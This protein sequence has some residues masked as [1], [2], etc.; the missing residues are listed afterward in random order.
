MTSDALCDL[1]L[2]VGRVENPG[3]SLDPRVSFLAET[4]STT[5]S[6]LRLEFLR[7]SIMLLNMDK[8]ESSDTE[9]LLFLLSLMELYPDSP[10]KE[11]SSGFLGIDIVAS[12]GLGVNSALPDLEASLV[13]G[14][15]PKIDLR[16]EVDS[17]KEQGTVLGGLRGVDV[18]RES[19]MVTIL[20]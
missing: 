18:D 3:R 16:M 4:F 6:K 13:T 11:E 10:R 15:T 19:V 20:A 8:L 5:C 12:P 1:G 2:E 7:E 9:L 17:S 14:L